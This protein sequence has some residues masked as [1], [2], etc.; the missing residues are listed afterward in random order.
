MFYM[1]IDMRPPPYLLNQAIYSA[2]RLYLHCNKNESFRH[3]QNNTCHFQPVPEA[4][5]DSP[6]EKK[7]RRKETKAPCHVFGALDVYEFANRLKKVQFLHLR[8]ARC[9]E[10]CVL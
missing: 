2:Y 7:F 5:D 8:Y 1:Y 9:L 3:L 10:K 6:K 4:D